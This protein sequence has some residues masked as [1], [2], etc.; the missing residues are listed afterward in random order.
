MR[1]SDWS[2]DV[3]SSDLGEAEAVGEEHVALQLLLERLGG[4]ALAVDR[5][6]DEAWGDA[7]DAD[8]GGGEVAGDG[9]GHADDTALGGGVGDLADLAVEGGHR[10]DGDDGALLVVRQRSEEHTSELQ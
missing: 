2:S 3:C 6:V 9:E 1:I 8:A 5:G 4:L 10:G 7:V